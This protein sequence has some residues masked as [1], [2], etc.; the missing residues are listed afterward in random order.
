MIKLARV[1]DI[2]IDLGTSNVLIYS[3]GSGIVLRQPAVVAIQYDTR[4]LVAVG[5]E[6]Y[7][8][9]GR[10]PGNIVALRP[11]RNGSVMEFDLCRRMLQYFVGQ[12]IG[13][14]IFARP[15]AVLSVPSGVMDIEKRALLSATF[16]S[17]VRKTE[18]LSRPVAAALGAGLPFE[19]A[20]GSMIVDIGA[21][22][23]DIAVLSNSQTALHA[24]RPIGG[25]HFTD[26]IIKY[27]RRKYSLLIGE[28]TADELKIA[29]GS[30]QAGSSSG[31]TMEVTGRSLVKKL[32][33]TV[34]VTADDLYEAMREPTMQLIEELQSVLERTSPQLASDIFSDGITL[35]GGGARLAGLAETIFNTLHVPCAA[36]DDPQACTANGCGQVVENYAL[37]RHLLERSRS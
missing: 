37:Y 14:H 32:P 15:R 11:L 8:M 4:E 16:D 3:K 24:F 33:E 10:T 12:V 7:Q 17:G 22:A 6:A 2:G 31:I 23:T 13:K 26:A 21:G 20:F 18:L 5:D 25:D 27:I 1:S 28:R 9:I 34:T 36:A 30:V 29:I 19:R 35:T